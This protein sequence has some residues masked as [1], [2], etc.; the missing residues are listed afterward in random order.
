MVNFD[1][2]GAGMGRYTA[3]NVQCQRWS[4]EMGKKDEDGESISKVLRHSSERS[5]FL[6]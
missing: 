5:T 1:V 2:G 3:S 6:G 4:I